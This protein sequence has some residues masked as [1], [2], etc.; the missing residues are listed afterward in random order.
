MEGREKKPSSIPK[1][2]RRR[3]RVVAVASAQAGLSKLE[4][5]EYIMSWW[6]ASCHVY[7]LYS[8]I[9][10]LYLILRLVLQPSR[11]YKR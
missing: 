6:C 11:V 2:S 7:L 1:H 9:D 8:E 5:G 3:P 4:G 10:R